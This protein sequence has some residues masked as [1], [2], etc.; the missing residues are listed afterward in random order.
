MMMHHSE[1]GPQKALY[2]SPSLSAVNMRKTYP[3]KPACSR[4]MM[5]AMGQSQAAL[6][7]SAEAIRDQPTDS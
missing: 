1:P 2:V 3:D 6:A 5:T 4:I 7:I